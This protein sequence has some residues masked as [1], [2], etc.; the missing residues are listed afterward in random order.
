[1]NVEIKQII[2]TLWKWKIL[3]LSVLGVTIIGLVGL[4]LTSQASYTAWVELQVTAPESESVAIFNDLRATSEREA[5]TI[6]RNNF[7]V[8]VESDLVRQQTIDELGLTKSEGEYELEVDPA[9]DADF[10]SISFTAVSPELAATIANT[11]IQKSI[12]RL[13]NLRA[14]PAQ[15]RLQE[16]ELEL[17][18]AE[19]VLRQVDITLAS[20]QDENNLSSSLEN[21]IATYEQR[22]QNLILSRSDLL[23]SDPFSANN[24]VEQIEALITDLEQQLLPLESIR[25][26]HAQL[27][28]AEEKAQSNYK[29][30]LQA[31]TGSVDLTSSVLPQPLSSAKQALDNSQAALSSFLAEN[32]IPTVE[33]DIALLNRQIQDLNAE[34]DQRLIAP[35]EEFQNAR[36]LTIDAL[37]EETEARVATLAALEPQYNL[38]QIQRQRAVDDYEFIL[39]KFNEAKIV[40]TAASSADFIQIIT[41]A[42]PPEEASSS[43]L[44]LV[45]F[46]FAGSLGLGIFLA[47]FL[48]YVT[49]AAEAEAGE[50]ERALPI[51]PNLDNFD[52]FELEEEPEA[53][54]AYQ[55]PIRLQQSAQGE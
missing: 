45:V 29:D 35:S 7:S 55:F 16:L 27:V 5:V 54:P 8:V 17:N 40:A 38:L 19:T 46:G 15:E 53:E 11:H 48:E 52:D 18:D 36:V 3:I 30:L 24:Q 25:H 50:E 41:L 6:A 31:S 33:N 12:D 22:L 23:I 9:L 1:M 39:Q 32:D 47:F 51:P 21:E 34:R 20:F 2:N 13:G 10:V 43:L 49:T 28:N 26:T 44:F 42:T 4:V 14:L 37:V